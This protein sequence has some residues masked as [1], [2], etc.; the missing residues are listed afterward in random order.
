MRKLLERLRCLIGDHD[1]T[2]AAAQGIPPT[3]RQLE[4]VGGFYDYATM[5]CSRCRR[6]SELSGKARAQRPWPAPPP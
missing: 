3:P 1:W 2:T 6:V 4:S 5:Y